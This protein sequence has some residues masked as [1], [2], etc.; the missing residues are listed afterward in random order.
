MR[1][2][3]IIILSI[4]LPAA[5]GLDASDGGALDGFWQLYAVDTL[6][7]GRS[8][9]ASR[10]GVYWAVE[11]RLLETRSPEAAPVLFRY[12]R[13]PDSLVLSQPYFDLRA[14]GDVPVTDPAALRPFGIDSLRQAFFIERLSSGHLTL[15]S[16]R[17]R[18]S[19]RKQ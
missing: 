2:F 14:E 8:A 16:A 3:L 13:T 15:R 4:T 7:S 5:C 17:L 9:D 18:L 12:E 1:H 10:S 11:H 6:A 19:F